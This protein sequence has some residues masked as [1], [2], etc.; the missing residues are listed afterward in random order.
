MDVWDLRTLNV[1][2]LRLVSL[3]YYKTVWIPVLAIDV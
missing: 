1:H 3:N 2:K